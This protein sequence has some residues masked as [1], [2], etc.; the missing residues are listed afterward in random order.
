MI[1]EIKKIVQN[2]LDNLKLS[3]LMIGTVE[4]SGIKISDR[5]TVPN[6]L[7]K[8]N[9]KDHIVAGDKVRLFRNLGGQEF[10]IVEIIDRQF[11]AKGSTVTLSL[12][13]ISNEYIVEDVSS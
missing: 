6:E 2:Y 12:N 9:M 1:S 3:C 7:V 8:G 4:S 10:Y 5:L 11:I 13:G